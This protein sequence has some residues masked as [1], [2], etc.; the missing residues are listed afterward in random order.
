M[1]YLYFYPGIYSLNKGCFSVQ[2]VKPKKYMAYNKKQ[3]ALI[4]K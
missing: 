2:T 1:G 3:K 4:L